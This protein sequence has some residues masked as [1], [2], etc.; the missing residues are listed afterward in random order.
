MSIRLWCLT[1]RECQDR[2]ETKDNGGVSAR[3]EREEVTYTL[4]AHLM[5]S[6]GKT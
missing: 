5:K 4:L 1:V 2:E 3:I 6:I